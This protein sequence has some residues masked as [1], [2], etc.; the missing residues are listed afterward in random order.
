[1]A[2]DDAAV[3]MADLFDPEPEVWGLRGDP[4]AWRDLR[5][6]LS[7]VDIPA[8]ADEVLSL[9]RVSFRDV[10]GVDLATERE[11]Q[12]YR[13]QYAHGGMSSGYVDLGTWR[14]RLLPMLAERAKV[15]LAD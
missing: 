1:M 7:G 6:H 5:D 10:V 8:S 9:L 11:S 4:Y 14:E 12:A 15:L 3:T 13:E 2:H